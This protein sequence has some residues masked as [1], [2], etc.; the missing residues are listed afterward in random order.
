MP[1]VLI[2]AHNEAAV[3]PRTLAVLA[4][5][6][7][8]DAEVWVLANGCTDATAQLAR[9]AGVR[10]LEV[11]EASKVAA[12]NAGDAAAP[13]YPRLYLDADIELSGSDAN[14]LFEALENGA[15][16]AEPRP[17]FDLTG[18]DGTVIAWYKVWQQ[19]H[20]A[21]PGAVGSGMYALSQAGRERFGAFPDVIADDGYVRAHFAPGEIELVEGTTS[22]VRGPLRLAELIKIKTR[23]R[24]GNLQL[25]RRYPEL[26]AAKAGASVGAKAAK[27]PVGLWPLLPLYGWVQLKVRRRAQAQAEHLDDYVWER[28]ESSRGE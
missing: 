5:G 12:L 10:V 21:R 24:L 20:G 22:R 23:S 15:L 3:L 26:M 25:K 17:V 2:P 16:A 4:Q 6:L 8:E 28:D 14:R 27:L 1:V 9:E 11:E 7:R 19:L 18:A 13:G